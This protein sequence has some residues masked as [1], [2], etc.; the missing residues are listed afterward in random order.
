MKKDAISYTEARDL[1]L[2]LP[3]RTE[4]ETVPLPK[5][6]GRVLAQPLFAEENVPPFDRSAYDGYAVRAADTADASDRHP[7]TL[8]ILEEIPAG[9][10]SRCSLTAGTAAKILTGAPIPEGC[11]S[12]VPFEKTTFTESE[13]TLTVP[14]RPGANVILAGEDVQS[15]SLLASAGTVIDAS[16]MASLAGQNVSHPCCF[17]IPKVGIISTGSE[18][19]DVGVPLAPGQIRN[20][21][22]YSLS[23]ALRSLGTEPVFLGIGRDNASQIASLI[24]QGLDRCD[25]VILTGG[26]SVGDYDL[27]PEAVTMAGADVLFE[28]LAMKPGKACCFGT[29]EGKLIAGLSGHPASS[30]IALCAVAAPYIKK[31]CGRRDFMNREIPVTLG[32]TLEKAASVTRLMWGTL[33]LTGGT[34]VV[35]L[36]SRQGNVIISS[37]IGTDVLAE[38]PAGSGPVEK[39]TTVKGFLI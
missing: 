31:L 16:L 13:V 22:R 30:L 19:L 15:G 36:S 20:T 5:C 29:A 3:M 33:D 7:V 26:V 2:S 27:T 21:N 18:L 37:I 25:A 1:L 35:H 9:G 14:C 32:E 6:W 10:V 39:G 11:D 4:T 34:A 28:R 38:I 8:R 12:V 24:R 17:R 23:G